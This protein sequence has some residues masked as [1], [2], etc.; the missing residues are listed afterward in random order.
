[1][2]Q[3]YCNRIHLHNAKCDVNVNNHINKGNIA[4]SI[5]CGRI[6]KKTNKPRDASVQQDGDLL[7]VIFLNHRNLLILIIAGIFFLM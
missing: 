6:Q 4:S 5:I 3:S 1:M 7:C 2:R